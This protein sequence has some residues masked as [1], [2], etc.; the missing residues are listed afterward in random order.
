MKAF[1]IIILLS[2]IFMEEFKGPRTIDNEAQAKIFFGWFTARG[3]RLVSLTHG[4]VFDWR[5][6]KGDN[7]IN[8]ANEFYQGILTGKIKF[9]EEKK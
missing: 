2:M 1:L 9:A 4:Q 8:T 5:F 3:G 6:L 7:L